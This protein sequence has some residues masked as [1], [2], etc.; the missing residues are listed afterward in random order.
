MPKYSLNRKLS[1]IA[2]AIA[3]VIIGVD[4]NMASKPVNAD[5]IDLSCPVGGETATYS[6]GLTNTPQLTTA[7]VDGAQTT[8]LIP[9]DKTIKSATYDFTLQANLSCL[10]LG[11]S[12]F[13][14]T[15]KFNNGKSSTVHYVSNQ[16]VRVGGQTVLTTIRTVISGE[17]VGDMATRTITLTTLSP[18]QCA[19]SGVT[20]NTGVVTLQFTSL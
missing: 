20:T 10:D 11:L 8:C 14:I 16:F 7:S 4:F 1:V 18:Q 3:V 19:T 12:P 2:C 9:S 17:F 6:P 13:D 5:V 15:Y